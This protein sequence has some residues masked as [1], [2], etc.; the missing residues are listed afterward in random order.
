MSV[1]ITTGNFVSAQYEGLQQ[2]GISPLCGCKD[3]LGSEEWR[4]I[5]FPVHNLL[6]WR[7]GPSPLTGYRLTSPVFGHITRLPHFSY[8][9]DWLEL[10]VPSDVAFDPAAVFER[11]LPPHYERLVRQSWRTKEVMLISGTSMNV[12]LSGSLPLAGWLPME[13]S[14]VEFGKATPIFPAENG[15]FHIQEATHAF[16]S[17]E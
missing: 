16:A 9:L 11:T 4:G 3:K 17:R 5:T 2:V 15:V 12:S 14:T 7:T 6:L 1:S 8:S 13:E 10:M